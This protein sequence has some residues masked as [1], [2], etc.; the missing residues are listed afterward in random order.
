MHKDNLRSFFDGLL[1]RKAPIII[2]RRFAQGDTMEQV[3]DFLTLFCW[4]GPRAA[5]ADRKR[6]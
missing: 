4:V 3:E 2:E 6:P 1:E 5:M